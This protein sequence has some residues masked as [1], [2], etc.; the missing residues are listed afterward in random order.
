MK[1]LGSRDYVAIVEGEITKRFSASVP[2]DIDR[3]RVR[4]MQ[5]WE[6]VVKLTS[7]EKGPMCQ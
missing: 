5:V 2:T 4:F 6:W 7:K 3:T 1:E